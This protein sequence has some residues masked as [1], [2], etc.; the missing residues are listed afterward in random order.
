MHSTFFDDT[1]QILFRLLFVPF[2]Y[3]NKK[4]IFLYSV[5]I[6]SVKPETLKVEPILSHYSFSCLAGVM[7]KFSNS[8]TSPLVLSVILKDWLTE[9]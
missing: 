3:F 4:T 1:T 5:D 9:I 6:L 7:S 2:K 8:S